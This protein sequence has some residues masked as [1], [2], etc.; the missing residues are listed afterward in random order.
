MC[1]YGTPVSSTNKTDHH[2]ITEILLTVAFTTINQTKPICL[3]KFTKI[4]KRIKLY[5]QLLCDKKYFRMYNVYNSV[6]GL[7]AV[8]CL[9]PLS[10]IFQ[11]FYEGQTC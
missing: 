7:V 2:D 5:G 9:T 1:S 3:Y 11:L 8:W 4:E 10:T 6:L